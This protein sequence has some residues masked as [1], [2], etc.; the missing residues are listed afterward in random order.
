MKNKQMQRI[1]AA[2]LSAQ[3][4]V[5]CM[6]TTVFAADVG[7]TF[8]SD[9]LTYKVLT[10][11]ADNTLGTVQVGNG[12]GSMNIS[13]SQVV[14]P[15]TVTNDENETYT[16]V[17]IAQNAFSNSSGDCSVGSVEIPDTVTTIGKSAFSELTSLNSVTFAEGSQLKSIGDN[18]FDTTRFSSITLPASLETIGEEA[19]TKCIYLSSV[20]MQEG[21]TS[22]GARAFSGDS[23]LSSIMLP[24]SLTELG[25]NVFE[26]C[27][28]LKT[29]AVADESTAFSS[30]DGVLF[31]KD[32]S[33]LVTYPAGKTDA[34]YTAPASVTAVGD[35][36]FA[37]NTKIQNVVLPDGVKTLGKYAFSKATNLT[38]LNPG[39][40]L[41][42]IGTLAFWNCSK[43]ESLTI[44]ATVTE[45]GSTAFYN[46]Y[47]TKFIVPSEELKTMVR[48]ADA[49]ED[50]IT[51]VA[52]P[53]D[54]TFAVDDVTYKVL[55]EP[56]DGQNGTVQI[57]DGDNA[58]ASSASGT[59]TIPATVMNG[60]KTY[61]V[62]SVADRAFMDSKITGITLP[63]SITTIGDHAF[64]GS[65]L[66]GFTMPS[67]VTEIGIYSFCD[68][69][70][71][72]SI[73]LS[74]NLTKIA[75]NAF[76]GSGLRTIA[77]P[78]GVTDIATLAFYSC[79]S[80]QTVS[81]PASLVTIQKQAFWAN[82][83][84][85]EVTIAK[86]SQMQ[87][88]G[89]IA[90]QWCNTLKNIQLPDTLKEI[91]K[92]AFS[93]C[94]SL[95]DI[96]LT[97]NSQLERLG[98]SAFASTK[99]SSFYYP[100]TL[101]TIGENILNDCTS[102][103]EIKVAENH[104][105]YKS[106]DGVLFNKDGT[107][108]LRYPANRK[109][110]EYTTPAGV[111]T[112]GSYAFQG[113]S[114]RLK[115]IVIGDG[116]KTIK[117][118]AFQNSQA[119]SITIA[120]TVTSMEKL[121]FYGCPYLESVKLSSGM[122]TLVTSAFWNCENLSALQIPA[123]VNTIESSAVGNC[124]N[125]ASIEILAEHLTSVGGNAFSN[126]SSA[127]TITV[128][129]D[130]AK[131]LVVASG[132]SEDQVIVKS[133]T[134][135]AP[136]GS[137]FTVN[138]VL[139]QIITTPEDGKSGTV[140]IGDG[141][142]GITASG[143]LTI[144]AVIQ[145]G[146]NSYD[147]V[148]VA[149][150]ALKGSTVTELH[151]P[152][153]VKTLA[154][155]ALYE[156]TELTAFE[157]P[158]GVESIGMNAIAGCSK[159]KSITYQ[160]GS[161]LKNLG[162]GALSDNPILE[163]IALPNTLVDIGTHTMFYNYKLR[164]VTFQDGAAWTELPAGTFQRD[165]ALERVTLPS[166]VTAIGEE[167]FWNCNALAQI[168]LSHM[169]E[170]GAKA[171]YHCTTLKSITLSDNLEKL[172]G[173]T[174]EG[175]TNLTSVHLGTGLKTLGDLRQTGEDALTGVFEG[176]TSLT[177]IQIPAATTVIGKN[178]FKDCTALG[179]IT[180]LSPALSAVGANPFYGL[181]DDYMITVQNENVKNTL[182]NIALV[183]ASHIQI[184]I[185][186]DPTAPKIALKDQGSGGLGKLAQ[187]TVTNGKSG[188]YLL[189]QIT[190]E[191]GVNSVYAVP[192]PQTGSMNISYASGSHV[193]VWLTERQPEMT[194]ST[195]NAGGQV[196][197][198]ASL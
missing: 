76:S 13:K 108:L 129:N 71:M 122:T 180:I 84:L 152:A 56:A 1:L 176:C 150:N 148:S 40:S 115:D 6:G 145:N 21:V 157:I 170:I 28:R 127:F 37:N 130:A 67:A 163:T 51:V 107:T 160:S 54:V 74:S 103:A 190:N 36:A 5:S 149:S 90:F 159:L 197:G 175:C 132:I 146:D 126:L 162:N 186:E 33:T 46:C 60:E 78:E 173:G 82:E 172:E 143:V 142:N 119:E 189:V 92:E 91:D 15:K 61:N 131:A 183:E 153:S 133:V 73:T 81:L 75:A 104:P 187:V 136:S 47:D 166:S 169:D 167:A 68:T 57:G 123:S 185:S 93:N 95:T 102:L 194:A 45:I 155:Q 112:I 41:E 59:L 114:S 177:T 135:P 124:Q 97:E 20:T 139:Y 86:N 174:F 34:D 64:R 48:S 151:L 30:E 116:V 38:T 14:I 58:A 66:T 27:T 118:F 3:L 181:A 158:S 29:I 42:A 26:S 193:N 35:Y 69:D 164:E 77:I 178:A 191:A 188:Y 9:G 85:R 80:L 100:A 43:L 111:K 192:V 137:T 11:P 138:G 101:R 88:I 52:P 89:E 50:N 144:P 62:V 165:I 96:G 140:Q 65:A 4:V 83:A 121:C 128:A 94:T 19:F 87:T 147:V 72:S 79:G 22:I 141:K 161:S 110:A 109:A 198:S 25:G 39:T 195:P 196:F 2:A 106:V 182:V 120:D 44:P 53:A 23:Y 55:T 8:E 117:A 154:D 18:A 63:D 156:A 168:D 184:G 99:L 105:D 17:S 70:S 49:S 31:T 32:K 179:K 134:P 10:E 24:A 16:V 7:D 125:L 12:W 113:T 171:F 98:D